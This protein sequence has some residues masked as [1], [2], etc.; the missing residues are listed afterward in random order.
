MSDL[1]RTIRN[2]IERELALDGVLAAGGGIDLSGGF[3]ALAAGELVL[4]GDDDVWRAIGATV[5]ELQ[6]EGAPVGELLWGFEQAVLCTVQRSDGAWLGVFTA[7]K[8][9]DASALALRAR[10]DAFKAHSF[11]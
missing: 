11:A 10:L 9:N 7:P 8:L 1:R 2:W 6:A 4:A 5:A 3:S